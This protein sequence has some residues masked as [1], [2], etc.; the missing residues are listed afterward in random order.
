MNRGAILVTEFVDCNAARGLIPPAHHRSLE[1][2]GEDGEDL[3]NEGWGLGIGERNDLG[4]YFRKI[5][6]YAA[7]DHFVGSLLSTL[8]TIFPA[9]ALGGPLEKSTCMSVP[10][11]TSTAP[12]V[13]IRA[14]HI[15][16]ETNF[17]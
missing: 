3:E 13:C 10:H 6:R 7:I 14:I 2:S 16:L 4:I 9:S 5:A 12:K 17:F 8:S 15:R 1:W 11:Q